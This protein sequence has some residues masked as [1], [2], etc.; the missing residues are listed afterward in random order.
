MRNKAGIKESQLIN[1][2]K[3]KAAKKLRG[4]SADLVENNPLSEILAAEGGESFVTYIEWLGLGKDPKLVVL[5]S[6][7]HYYYDA[8]EMKNIQTVVSLKELNQIKQINN[9]LHSIFHTLPPKGYFIGCFVDNK[10]QNGFVLRNN[11]SDHHI[12]KDS[13]AVENGILSRIPFL[14][15]LF[16]FLDLKTNKYMSGRN[17]TLLLE[18]HG[19][20]VIDMTELDGLTYFCT[21]S[22]RTVD[23]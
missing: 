23:N 8:E 18:D 6:L 9:F 20:K 12:K 21:Q 17:V 2:Q 22:L 13:A 7:H 3:I 10:R 11:Y 16:S 5:S 14:N 1:N 4:T 19:F 15:T